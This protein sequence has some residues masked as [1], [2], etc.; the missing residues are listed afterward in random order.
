[1]LDVL[2]LDPATRAVTTVPGPSDLN[3]LPV[4]RVIVSG[5]VSP[6]DHGR[7]SIALGAFALRGGVVTGLPLRD[8][9]A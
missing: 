3:R 7:W 9:A 8:V 4:G 2:H 1:M 5:H 6:T